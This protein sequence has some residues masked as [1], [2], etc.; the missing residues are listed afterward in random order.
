MHVT[1]EFCAIPDSEPHICSQASTSRRRGRRARTSRWWTDCHDFVQVTSL[2]DLENHVQLG[3]KFP[4]A[5][6]EGAHQH[7]VDLGR[8]SEASFMSPE[9]NTFPLV[10]RLETVTERGAKEGH[11]LQVG[12]A[13]TWTYTRRHT[14]IAGMAWQCWSPARRRPAH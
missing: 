4:N 12:P 2:T 11:S 14:G 7:V 8:H 5:G 3:F 13:A 6:A 9:G 10:I 1:H